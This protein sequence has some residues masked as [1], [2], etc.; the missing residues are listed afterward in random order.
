MSECLILADR[1]QQFYFGNPDRLTI[2]DPN[3]HDNDISGGTKEIQLIIRAFSNAYDTLKNR[4]EYLALVQGPN[5]S[6]LEPIIAANFDEYLEQRYQLRQVFMSEERFARYRPPPPPP[7]PPPADETFLPPPPLPAGPPPT[8]GACS[9][10]FPAPPAPKPVKKPVKSS[11][12]KSNGTKSEPVDI[13][14]DESP[15][16]GE[17][18]TA[19]ARRGETRRHLCQERAARLKRL[20]PDLKKLPNTLSL[21]QARRHAGYETDA[22]MNADLDAREKKLLAST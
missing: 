21:S 16:Q 8:D 13:S 14:S 11:K 3:N 17:A 15:E 7:G 10:F 4:L 12:A 2:E 9:T 6:I 5:K 19:K 20:R 22:E 1:I 18:K